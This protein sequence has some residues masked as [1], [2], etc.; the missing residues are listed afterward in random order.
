[1]EFSRESI[2]G[3]AARS[4]FK[5]VATIVG[6]GIGLG[7]VAIG[8]GVLVES[9]SNIPP[10]KSQA[11]LA[12]DAEGNR[13]LLPESAP[14]VLRL[15]FHGI[16]GAG[17]LTSEKIENV[18]LDSQEDSFKDG[19]VKAILLH[20]NTPG[21]AARDSD[22]IYRALIA[23]KKKHNVPIY[24]YVDGLCASGGMYI[25][26]A[27]DKIYSSHSS[28][29]GSVGVIMGPAF[30]FT[31]A[32]TKYGVSALTLTEGKDKDA[33]NPFR[34]WKPNEDA[35]LKAVMSVLY[36]QFITIVSEARPKLTKEL[37][38]NTYG[39]RVFAAI[40]A[41][42]NGYID[43]WNS[44]YS[45]AVKHLAEAAQIGE[46]EQYQVIQ[47]CPPRAFLGNFAQSLA[48]TKIIHSVLGKEDLSELNGKILYYYQP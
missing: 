19:R 28:V 46:K 13:A 29:I 48:P 16:I 3:A 7:I 47:L 45:E 39:A 14:V 44:N 38:I 43:A 18:L 22:N 31:D 37:L 11:L 33:L 41:E 27:A 35:S 1:M 26:S 42:Q 5:S 23:Y 9:K 21:G 32:M 24:A 10:P 34:P 15:D 30:N 17:D 6:I 36:D 12:P 8:I 40:D 4:F 2:F 25:A 20:M